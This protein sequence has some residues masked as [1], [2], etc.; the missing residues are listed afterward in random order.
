MCWNFRRNKPQIVR[1]DRAEAQ[2]T[3]NTKYGTNRKL[4]DSPWRNCLAFSHVK[5]II[6]RSEQHFG[7]SRIFIK[8]YRASSSN[9]SARLSSVN[10]LL[11]LNSQIFPVSQNILTKKI[12]RP[13][14]FKKERPIRVCKSYTILI[15]FSA[16]VWLD[17]HLLT[18]CYGLQN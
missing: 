2:R 10:L 18:S 3:G 12:W 8:L 16:D 6:Y 9:F 4:D 17:L 11:C 1:I 13:E 15:F 5:N 14:F 7:S